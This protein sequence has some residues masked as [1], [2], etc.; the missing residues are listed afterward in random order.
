LQNYE[1]VSATWLQKPQ[2]ASFFLS[3]TFCEKR[4]TAAYDC[5]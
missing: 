4:K 5:S 2:L 1:K 3:D